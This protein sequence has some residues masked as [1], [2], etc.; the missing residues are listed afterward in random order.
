MC[1]YVLP[2][3]NGLFNLGQVYWRGGNSSNWNETRERQL[4]ET[5]A[6]ANIV[7][8]QANADLCVFLQHGIRFYQDIVNRLQVWHITPAFIM[9]EA[10]R[11]PRG[12]RLGSATTPTRGSVRSMCYPVDS[13]LKCAPPCYVQMQH[14]FRLAVRQG[15]DN[16]WDTFPEHL[17]I[18][19]NSQGT[20]PAADEM[21]M[22]RLAQLTMYAGHACCIWRAL[23]AACT[24]FRIARQYHNIL[25]RSRRQTSLLC[26]YGRPRAV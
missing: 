19:V 3:Y 8:T 25:I 14:G 18:S 6:A 23:A 26:L 22:M 5:I 13:W 4:Q 20:A 24:W 10:K 2:A 7:V 11:V 12:L 1:A 15:K 9:D 16:T 21:K 17:Y